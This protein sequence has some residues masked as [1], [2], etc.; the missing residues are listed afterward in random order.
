MH[1]VTVDRINKLVEVRLSGMLDVAAME[2]SG[3]RDARRGALA[4]ASG[5]GAHV[6]LYDIS[7]AGLSIGAAG[8]SLARLR[9]MG[10][11]A[12]LPACAGARW[13]CVVPSAL[14]RM[15]I[16]GAESRRATT[17]RCSRARAEAMRW[18]FA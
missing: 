5:P 9:A 11:S 18:L 15:K 3:T 12:L 17:W 14:N 8:G 1:R 13:R 10:R 4:G 7:D 2:A 16:A 6:S